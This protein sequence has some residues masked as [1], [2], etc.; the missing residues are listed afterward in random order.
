[1]SQLAALVAGVLFGAGLILGGMTQPTKVI[2]FLDFLGNWDPSLAL[3]MGGAILV[4][5][6]AW[7]WIT[8][9][10][11][12]LAGGAFVLPDRRDIDAPLLAGA[13][14][15]GLG[16]GLAGFCPGPALTALAAGMPQALIFVGAMLAGMGLYEVLA[17]RG[18]TG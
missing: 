6:P 3:V 16:R 8:P 9:R 2:G 14:L 17:S 7:R 10:P 5:A 11:A 18:S 15:F 4:Y 13:V 12:P 1:M